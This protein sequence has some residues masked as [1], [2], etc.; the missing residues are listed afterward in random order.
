V[1]HPKRESGQES[2]SGFLS[3]AG[4][5]LVASCPD[6]DFSA[7]CETFGRD[8]SAERYAA[9][10]PACEDPVAVPTAYGIRQE[11]SRVLREEQQN[12]VDFWLLPSGIVLFGAE[13][14]ERLYPNR[15]ADGQLYC[16]GKTVVVSRPD[17]LDF[18]AAELGEIDS[19]YC[20]TTKSGAGDSI[21]KSDIESFFG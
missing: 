9:P 10:Q 8:F 17:W 21:S 14:P 16:C 11:N 12:R 20:A 7:L 1:L 5:R 4:S 6:E 15:Q 3:R 13:H 2:P 18:V 19:D